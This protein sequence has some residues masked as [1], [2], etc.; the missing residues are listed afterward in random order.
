MRY[1]EPA[2][3]SREATLA[4][5]RAGTLDEVR[6]AII[7]ASLNAS[8]PTWVEAMCLDVA[9]TRDDCGIQGAAV[10]GLA[11]LAR[12]FRHLDDCTA[13]EAVLLQLRDVPDLAGR[14]NDG[15]DD[16]AT[17]LAP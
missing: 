2:F 4:T 3:R 6:D 9:R 7:G 1:E 14:A 16:F 8:D 13:A 12:R 17:F 15:R 11:H 10:L 5:I